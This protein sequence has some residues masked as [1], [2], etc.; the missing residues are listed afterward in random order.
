MKTKQTYVVLRYSRFFFLGGPA[1]SQDA[2]TDSTGSKSLWK[3]LHRRDGL[4]H[5]L[6]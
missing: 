1:H 5:S 3:N 4:V 2:G 6:S